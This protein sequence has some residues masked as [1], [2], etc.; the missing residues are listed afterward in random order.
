[1]SSLSPLNGRTMCPSMKFLVFEGRDSGDQCEDDC[2]RRCCTPN[3]RLG[4]CESV[5][6]SAGQTAPRVRERQHGRRSQLLAGG[7]EQHQHHARYLPHPHNLLLVRPCRATLPAYAT[8]L[9]AACVQI[10]RG[11]CSS[12]TYSSNH[13]RGRRKRRTIMQKYLHP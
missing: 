10:S 4:V 12:A 6:L 5:F 11:G 1:M 2:V 9:P 13:S 7:A 8:P 3:G